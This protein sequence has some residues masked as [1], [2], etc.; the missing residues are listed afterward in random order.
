MLTQTPVLKYST[1][2][3]LIAKPRN[4]QTNWQ[5]VYRWKKNKRGYRYKGILHGNEQRGG[6]LMHV[7]AGW[8]SPVQMRETRH[9]RLHIMWFHV[10]GFLHTAQLLAQKCI[11]VCQGIGVEEGVWWQIAQGSIFERW[12]IFYIFVV[13]PF[14]PRYIFVKNLQT[15][16]C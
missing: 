13:V 14:T 8:V 6:I 16:I 9:R 10:N 1:R 5:L 15:V 2:V 12:D 3:F 7:T 4:N 11:C